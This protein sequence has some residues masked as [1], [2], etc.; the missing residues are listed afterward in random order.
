[1][2]GAASLLVSPLLLVSTEVMVVLFGPPYGAAGDVLAV[3]AI[4]L[5]IVASVSP[6]SA[7]LQGQDHE[8]F[9]SRVGLAF[10]PV[11]IAGMV[12]GASWWGIVGV[13]VG[14][15]ISYLIRSGVLIFRCM[16]FVGDELT[17]RGSENVTKNDHGIAL[18]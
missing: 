2:A 10:F 15:G 8:R 11:S 17:R 1:M 12:L 16:R 18:G 3:T 14:V 7:I 6:L 4:F 13:A 5:P 9:A